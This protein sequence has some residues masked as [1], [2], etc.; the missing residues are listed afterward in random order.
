MQ[1]YSK[2]MA[3][4]IQEV[5]FLVDLYHLDIA[6]LDIVFGVA[7]MRSLRCILIDYHALTIEFMLNGKHTILHAE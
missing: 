6:G 1:G 7:W 5:K 2:A 4:I 3:I